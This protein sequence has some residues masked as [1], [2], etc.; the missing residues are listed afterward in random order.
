VIEGH[1][2]TVIAV[3]VSEQDVAPIVQIHLP[4]APGEFHLR[5]TAPF[6]GQLDATSRGRPLDLPTVDTPTA[7]EFHYWI[8]C[9]SQLLPQTLET[10]SQNSDV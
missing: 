2:E 1:P 10:R 3:L 7:L 6:R 5:A 8:A 4:A 9:P